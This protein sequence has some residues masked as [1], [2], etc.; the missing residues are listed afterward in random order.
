MRRKMNFVTTPNK[1]SVLRKF[2]AG[3]TISDVYSMDS[4][5]TNPRKFYSSTFEP[6]VSSRKIS[7]K[8]S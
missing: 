7:T 4:D 6:Q 5:L 3:T 1:P 2:E 8:R